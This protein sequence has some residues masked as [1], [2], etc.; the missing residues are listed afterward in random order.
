MMNDPELTKVLQGYAKT[1][2]IRLTRQGEATVAEVKV[3]PAWIIEI[4]I[5]EGIFEW[6]VSIR[7]EGDDRAILEDWCDHWEPTEE[8]SIIDRRDEIQSL[9]ESLV[10]KPTRMKSVEKKA[11]IPW[12]KRS[13]KY[14]LEFLDGGV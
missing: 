4:C 9:I 6:F 14:S 2:R 3:P 8:Q 7:A 12:R 1:G 11:L 13:T 10:R 5:P